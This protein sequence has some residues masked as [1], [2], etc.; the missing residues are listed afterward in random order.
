VWVAYDRDA[1]RVCAFQLGRRDR[2]AATKLWQQLDLFNIK[3]VCTD[4]YPVYEAVI[5]SHL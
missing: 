2:T 4:D 1:R 5:P 3:H